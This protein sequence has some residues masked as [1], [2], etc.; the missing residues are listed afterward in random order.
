[1]TNLAMWSLIVGF[2]L[3]IIIPVIQQ[4]GWAK[5]ARATVTLVI[6]LA[7]GGLTAY[8]NG[9]LNGQ[10]WITSALI[11][12]VAAITAYKG[13]FQPTGIAPM[14]ETMTSPKPLPEG[15]EVEEGSQ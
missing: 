1:M 4:P 7:V 11:V 8:F 14:I 2:V 5:W 3:P 12:F 13:F 9:D 10:D 15:V 6:V